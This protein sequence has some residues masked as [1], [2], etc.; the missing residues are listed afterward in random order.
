MVILWSSESRRLVTVHPN[1]RAVVWMNRKTGSV[2][3]P[4]VNNVGM[5]DRYKNNGY[6]RVEFKNLH[7]LDRFCSDRKLVNEKASFDNSGHADEL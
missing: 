6:R 7:A 2:A 1:E 4:P 3:Y 5:P